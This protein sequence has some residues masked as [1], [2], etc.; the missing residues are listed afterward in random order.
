VNARPRRDLTGF[1]EDLEA[2]RNGEMR[3]IYAGEPGTLIFECEIM[4]P[5]SSK[6]RTIYVYFGG[7]DLTDALKAMRDEAIRVRSQPME[8]PQHRGEA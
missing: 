4:H 8:V 1:T 3:L 2:E 5:P 7:D 6:G